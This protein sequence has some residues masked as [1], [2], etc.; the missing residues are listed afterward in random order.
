MKK[1][2]CYL[3]LVF[4]LSVAFSQT[5]F[6]HGPY[7]HHHYDDDR[8]FFRD[9][10]YHRRG[11]FGWD[12][13]VDI[14]PIGA[15]IMDLPAGYTVITIGGVP[16][17]YYNEIYYRPCPGGYV[18]VEK[19]VIVYKE[20]V[21]EKIVVPT[22]GDPLTVNVPNSDGTYTPVKLTPKNNGYT[23]PQGEY[24]EGHPTVE[25]LRVLYG[26]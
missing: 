3:L 15:M 1:A 17:Y 19:P 9:G 21:V 23:G 18:V 16:Y 5:V 4:S 14:P 8:Y 12:I 25:Q 6:A 26:K 20:P 7:D 13:L 24:Y 22:G 11:W 10:R 2:G